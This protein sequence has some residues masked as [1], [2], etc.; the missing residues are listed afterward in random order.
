VAQ[1]A[2][3]LASSRAQRLPQPSR[4]A[5]AEMREPETREPGK[6]RGVHSCVAVISD[7]DRVVSVRLAARAAHQHGC[8]VLVICPSRRPELRC[9]AL[10]NVGRDAGSALEY[11]AT[12]YTSSWPRRRRL[13]RGIAAQA[14]PAAPLP[15][16]ARAGK[17]L[18]GGTRSVARAGGVFSSTHGCGLRLRFCTTAV[19]AMHLWPRSWGQP[20]LAR[21]LPCPPLGA[22]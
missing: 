8:E 21:R 20:L 19:H 5:A 12:H 16:A 9:T 17:R 1:H 14:R 11:V 4:A 3:N 18:S 15:G 7:Y 6:P 2:G 22:E 10:P 13:R